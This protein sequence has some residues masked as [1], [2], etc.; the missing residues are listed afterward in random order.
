MT[1]AWCA[2]TLA[3][4][5]GERGRN[6]VVSLCGAGAPPNISLDPAW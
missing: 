5:Y 2:R 4:P 6:G 1:V 3:E